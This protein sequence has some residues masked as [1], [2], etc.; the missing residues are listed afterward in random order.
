MNW[1]QKFSDFNKTAEYEEQ[2]VHFDTF[3]KHMKENDQNFSDDDIIESWIGYLPNNLKTPSATGYKLAPQFYEEMRRYL[4]GK[5]ILL[6]D[7][8]KGSTNTPQNLNVPQEQQQTEY[9][10]KINGLPWQKYLETFVEEY[11]IDQKLDE[12]D[13]NDS[14]RESLEDSDLEL[15]QEAVNRF[16]LHLRKRWCP[17]LFRRVMGGEAEIADPRWKKQFKEF[18]VAKWGYNPFESDDWEAQTEDDTPSA[19]ELREQWGF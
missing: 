4:A 16:L 19:D 9:C 3:Y 6:E 10:S 14:W 7:V 5:N 11:I 1:F 13:E 2:K 12:S 18:C 8:Y 15:V 17:N